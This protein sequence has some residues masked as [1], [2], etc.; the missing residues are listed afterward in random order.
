MRVIAA[1][2]DCPFHF[3]KWQFEVYLIPTSPA[4]AK[5]HPPRIFLA[6]EAQSSLVLVQALLG[7]IFFAFFS[8]LLP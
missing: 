5:L 8:N 2:N 4:G 1:R 6:N 3:E 7:C